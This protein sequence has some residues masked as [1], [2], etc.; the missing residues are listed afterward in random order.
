MKH[1]QYFAWAS[2]STRSNK[3]KVQAKKTKEIDNYVSSLIS[4][5][6]N[7]CIVVIASIQ[8]QSDNSKT[9]MQ[10]V[11]QINLE[12][13]GAKEKMIL[14]IMNMLEMLFFF[15]WHWHCV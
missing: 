4:Q 2:K 9:C 7:L 6:Y 3:V 11:N 14:F 5:L 8:N 15:V 1:D 13:G 10:N 12:A